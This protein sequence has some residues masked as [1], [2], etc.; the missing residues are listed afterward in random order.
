MHCCKIA[1]TLISRLQ[2]KGMAT[3]LHTKGFCASNLTDYPRS[4][5]S[6]FFLLFALGHAQFGR[7]THTHTKVQ[8]RLL[9]EGQINAYLFNCVHP[10][11]ASY[12]VTFHTAF[13]SRD[14][15]FSPVCRLSWLGR[16]SCVIQAVSDEHLDRPSSVIL[17]NSGI[18]SLDNIGSSLS[19]TCV[20]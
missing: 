18:E 2:Q 4:F 13:T 5:K 6:H 10:K 14:V 15:T 1:L 19:E 17:G 12:P 9:I 20:G 8:T 7:E 16:R 3:P 11:S